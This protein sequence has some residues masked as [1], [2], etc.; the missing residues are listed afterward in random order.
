[1]QVCICL[2]AAKNDIHSKRYEI[3]YHWSVF[4][5]KHY[6]LLNF[7]KLLNKEQG[8]VISIVSLHRMCQQGANGTGAYE[9]GI[10]Q[11]LLSF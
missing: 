7:T 6:K 8:K 5:G 3:L 2:N 9:S 4:R 11:A 10:P 1:M